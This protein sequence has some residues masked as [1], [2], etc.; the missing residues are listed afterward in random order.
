NDQYLHT[1][2]VSGMFKVAALPGRGLIGARAQGGDRYRMGVGADQIKGKD[3]DGLFRTFPYLVHDRNFHT[4][5]E[6]NPAKDA[7][8][9]TIGMLLDPGLALTGTVLGPDGKPL[10]GALA[11]GLDSFG[12]GSWG[13][14]PLETAKFTALGLEPGETRLLQFFHKEKQLS[15]SVVI[16]ADQK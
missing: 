2:G 10:A 15:G 6:V 1:D 14:L 4:L 5:V 11:G 13:H 9:V 7:G 3:E 12:G 16:K 8:A